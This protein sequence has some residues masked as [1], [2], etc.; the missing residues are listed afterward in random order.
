V[1][2]QKYKV[3]DFLGRGGTGVVYSVVKEPAGIRGAMKVM[4]PSVARRPRLVESFLSEARMLASI[5][6]QNIVEVIDY[7]T[8]PDGTPFMVMQLLKGKTLRS[9]L[10]EMGRAVSARNVHNIFVQLCDGLLELHSQRAPIVH[11]DVKPENIFLHRASLGP[12]IVVKLLDFGLAGPSNQWSRHL[13][14]TPRFMAPEQVLGK[15]VTDRSDQYSAALVLYEMMTGRLPWDVD[16]KSVQAMVSAHVKL[17]PYPPSKFC[18][19][20]SKHVDEVILRGLEKDPSHRWSSVDQFCDGLR[21]L[22][23]VDDGSAFTNVDINTTARDLATMAGG[24]SVTSGAPSEDFVL[25]DTEQR[26][27]APPLG[28]RSL[29][30]PQFYFADEDPVWS[31][32]VRPPSE[33]AHDDGPAAGRSRAISARGAGDGLLSDE[34]FALSALATAQAPDAV[35]LRRALRLGET[36]DWDGGADPLEGGVLPVREEP[37]VAAP[38]SEGLVLARTPREPSRLAHMQGSRVPTVALALSVSI[39]L[40]LSLVPQVASRE[41][42]APAFVKGEGRPSDAVLLGGA[43]RADPIGGL[44]LESSAAQVAPPEPTG[45]LPTPIHAPASDPAPGAGLHAAV[46]KRRP[47]APRRAS[48]VPAASSETGAAAPAGEW[49]L[50]LEPSSRPNPQSPEPW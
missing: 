3:E 17:P 24:G 7:D 21:E 9:S 36:L 34:R 31:A 46:D 12:D 28:D 38:T 18:P 30:L 13:V 16:V 33:L 25:H 42:Y 22:Q 20:A 26:M 37:S 8:L 2:G 45:A 5:R 1:P 41:A 10:R 47:A 44:H 32:A 35:D 15:P 4:L 11:R 29:E 27:D 23:D 48:R 19:W 6:H 49:K 43:S 40:V 14:G 50:L 39:G